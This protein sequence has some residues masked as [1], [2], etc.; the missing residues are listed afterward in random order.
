MNEINPRKWISVTKNLTAIRIIR[1][2]AEKEHNDFHSLIWH[3]IKFDF[4]ANAHLLKMS[5]S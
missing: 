3:Q 4:V 5:Q 2:S 1:V